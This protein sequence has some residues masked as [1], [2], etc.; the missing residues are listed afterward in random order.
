MTRRFSAEWLD[1]ITGI[2]EKWLRR[3]N[4]LPEEGILIKAAGLRVILAACTQV[5]AYDDGSIAW[6]GPSGLFS[7]EPV[8]EQPAVEHQ[9]DLCETSPRTHLRRDDG[10]QGPADAAEARPG[11]RRQQG[12]GR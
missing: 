3:C 2:A 8:R 1:E 12:L 4:G 5:T 6:R 11:R 9:F 10:T 7:A